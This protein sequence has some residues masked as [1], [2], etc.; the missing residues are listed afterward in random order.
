MAIEQKISAGDKAVKD[1]D[2]LGAI[3]S[4]SDAVKE[5]PKAFAPYLKRANAYQK[6]KNYDD[7]K[8]DVSRAFLIAQERGKRAD[9]GLCYFKLGLLYYLEKKY[10][11]AVKQIHAAAKY[12]C[13]EPTLD[14]WKNKMEYDA[15]KHPEELPEEDI[16]D[17]KLDDSDQTK[18]NEVPKDNKKA[19]TTAEEEKKQDQQK[20]TNTSTSIDEINK[21]APLRV[22][23]REDWYQTDSE[24]IITIYAKNVKA[25]TFSLQYNPRSV[26]VLFP[27]GASSEYNYHLEPLY[28][29]ID[30]EKSTHKIYGTKVELV[31]H[32]STKRKWASLEGSD[33]PLP[34][35]SVA[36][37]NSSA[38]MSYPSSS[39]KAINWSNFQV[40]EDDENELE[41]FFKKL[42]KDVD[43]DTR[44]AMMKSYVQSNGTVLTTNWSE[45]KD[46]EF[47]TSPP[48]GMEAKKW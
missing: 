5:N 20:P 28:D 42:Y 41:D 38:P 14:M 47:E 36:Q 18:D 30:T 27:N 46:K 32:K 3:S 40:D 12:D 34:M 44:R 21:H 6:L 48:E 4:Y 10:H 25:D 23:I 31:L 8:A 37:S 33:E 9:I 16:F 22:K 35:A 15:K 11:L 19:V 45:A 17:L 39:K 29:E 1:G 2:Y 13:Q 24:V 43:D 26:S 7:A